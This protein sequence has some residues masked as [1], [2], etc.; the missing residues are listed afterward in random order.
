MVSAAAILQQH[1]ETLNTG[2]KDLL[3]HETLGQD[4]L[5]NLDANLKGEAG[6]RLPIAA[7]RA[8]GAL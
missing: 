5:R 4:Q 1:R 3:A 2:A 6:G 8:S 7:S